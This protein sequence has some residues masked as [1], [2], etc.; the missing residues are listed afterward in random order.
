[1]VQL[2]AQRDHA[3]RFLKREVPS[4]FWLEVFHHFNTCN[5][6]EERM[7]TLKATYGLGLAVTYRKFLSYFGAV[8]IPKTSHGRLESHWVCP[9][10]GT[11]YMDPTNAIYAMVFKL[12]WPDTLEELNKSNNETIGDLV[13]ALLGW[14]YLTKVT[15]TMTVI[16]SC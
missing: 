6:K 3:I 8:Q 15:H 5:Q 13:E 1:M 4:E 2:F 16:L 10:T 7:R 11:A 9:K 12:C 14:F